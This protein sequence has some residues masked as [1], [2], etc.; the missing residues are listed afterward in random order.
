[1]MYKTAVRKYAQFLENINF[2]IVKNRSA[3]IRRPN[4]SAVNRKRTLS[5]LK[6]Q[7][8][9]SAMSSKIKAGYFFTVSR[10][11]RQLCLKNMSLVMSVIKKGARY[12]KTITSKILQTVMKS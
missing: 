12:R 9:R 8:M 1:M 2:M 5:Q 11:A 10:T 6:I 3:G 7:L 4:R